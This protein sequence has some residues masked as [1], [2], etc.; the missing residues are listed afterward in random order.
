MKSTERSNEILQGD[1]VKLLAAL[2][3]ASVD[4]VFADPP[5]NIGYEYDVYHDKKEARDYLAW[6]RSWIAGVHRVLK[7]SGTF[8]LAIGD[9]FAAEFL[10][11][12]RVPTPSRRN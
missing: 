3:E 2:P 5:F 12:E 4:L 6:S 9:E 7:P 11:L 1:C 8:W 10:I